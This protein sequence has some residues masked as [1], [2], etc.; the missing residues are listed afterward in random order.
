METI[1]ILD[2]ITSLENKMDKLENKIDKIANFIYEMHELQ[3]NKIYNCEFDHTLNI[4]RKCDNCNKY[5]CHEN[6]CIGKCR[7]IYNK[8]TNR[9]DLL[10]YCNDC[11]AIK[12]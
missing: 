4:K 6:Q 9:Y 10:Y 2:K 5:K 3:K 8:N 7:E 11:I 12:N 1:S